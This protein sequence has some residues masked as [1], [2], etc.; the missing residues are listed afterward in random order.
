[1]VKSRKMRKVLL[2]L[3]LTTLF[4]G[5]VWAV[6]TMLASA[7]KQCDDAATLGAKDEL[8]TVQT[9][10]V[11]PKKPAPNIDWKTIGKFN[12]QLEG[13]NREYEQLLSKASSE[14]AA[15][16]LSESTR[17]GGLAS[18][19]KFNNT[20]VQL[21]EVYRKGNCITRA[22]TVTS[23][24]LSRL[25]NAEMAFSQTLDADKIS[26]YNDQRSA[27][28]DDSEANL[29]ELKTDG[30]EQDVARL[31][32]TMLPRLQQMSSQT[33]SL[34]AEIGKLLDQVRQAAGGDVGAMAG[35]AKQ[36]VTG[37][38]EGPAGLLRP[39]MAL[40]NMAKN[41]GSNLVTMA[42]SITSL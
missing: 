35:C 7:N 40:M 32:A 16:A 12:K 19:D 37:G 15:G 29:K 18:A 20:S 11:R 9:T 25:K 6:D 13:I 21:A 4:A 26:A 33:T 34:I 23:A 30:N 39:L 36:V 27:M 41:L 8:A 24:G 5:L 28:F 1:M 42:S 17:K 10:M 3:A 38:A 31:K 2:W 14:K 22:K